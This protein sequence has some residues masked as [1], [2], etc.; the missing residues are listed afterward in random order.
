[1][2]NRTSTW[3]INVPA[4]VIVVMIISVAVAGEFWIVVDVVVVVAVV[5][6]VV[7]VVDEGVAVVVIAV[8]VAVVVVAVVVVIIGIVGIVVAFII[9]CVVFRIDERRWKHFFIFSGLMFIIVYQK[10]IGF[11]V[12]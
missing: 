2:S 8:V 12:P 4:M 5:D 1:M 3:S 9:F 7:A 11:S 6:V 10:W